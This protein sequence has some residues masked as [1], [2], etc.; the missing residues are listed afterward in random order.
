[1]LSLRTDSQVLQEK[2]IEYETDQL[3]NNIEVLEMSKLADDLMEQIQS[4]YL[5]EDKQTL[6]RAVD[7]V[8]QAL[9][10]MAIAIGKNNPPQADIDNLNEAI[11]FQIAQIVVN[12]N[13]TVGKPKFI[14]GFTKLK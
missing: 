4:P 8:S 11:Q 12:Y 10:K 6:Q 5:T 9:Q 2:L 13:R 14:S 7:E 1:M 3:I